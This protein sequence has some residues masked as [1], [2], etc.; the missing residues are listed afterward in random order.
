MVQYLW[1]VADLED[2]AEALAE[3]MLQAGGVP[4]DAAEIRAGV[5]AGLVRDVGRALEVVRDKKR[6]Q[7][8]VVV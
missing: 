8:G 7:A 1:S 2:F 3:G 6:R 5:V 4:E